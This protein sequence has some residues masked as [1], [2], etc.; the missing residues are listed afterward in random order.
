MPTNIEL[1]LSSGSTESISRVASLRRVVITPVIALYF[2]A[3]L[4][5]RSC[6][7][8]RGIFANPVHNTLR[9]FWCCRREELNV[10]KGYFLNV[11]K[12]IRSSPTEFVRFSHRREMHRMPFNSALIPWF[13][14]LFWGVA[15]NEV[16]HCWGDRAKQNNQV[17]PYVFCNAF[18]PD[19]AKSASRFWYINCL[20]SWGVL[21]NMSGFHCQLLS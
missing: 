12:S 9:H 11:V 19:Q 5:P 21:Q 1:S 2:F 14:L 17:F 4:D 8:F 18:L 20:V 3:G 10:L 15:T 6:Q 7:R 16:V 13:A